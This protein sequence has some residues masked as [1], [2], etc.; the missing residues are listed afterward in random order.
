[1]KNTWRIKTV[2]LYNYN[3]GCMRPCFVLHRGRL[4]PTSRTSAKH[5]RCILGRN[6]DQRWSQKENATVQIREHEH[7]EQ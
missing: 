5:R 4:Y 7:W 3:L 2:S 1:M 6:D